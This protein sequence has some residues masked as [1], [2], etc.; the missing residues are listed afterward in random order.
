MYYLK[1]TTYA[2]LALLLL[3]TA[4]SKDEDPTPVGQ[5]PTANAG[6]DVQAT[7]NSSVPLN[8]SG[9]A[10]PD[11]GSLTYA[12]A[13]TTRPDGSSASIAGAAQATT[14]FTPDVVGTYVATLT[15]TDTDNNNASDAVTIEVS[16]AVGS[17]P[18]AAITDKNGRAIRE[19]N[20]N[21][22]LTVTS[23]Y[24]LDGSRSSDPDQDDLTYAWELA[25]KPEGSQTATISGSD[26][27]QAVFTPDV[28]GEYVI[29]LTVSDPGGNTNATDV[30]LVANASPVIVSGIISADTVWKDIFADPNVPDYLV[31]G[32][33]TAAAELTV[34]PGVVVHL[35]EDVVFTIDENGG[36]LIAEGTADQGIVFTSSDV[37]GEVRW[38]G[39]LINSSSSNNVLNY[40]TVS[41]AGGID[42]I[43]YEAG[44]RSA[45]I[46]ISADGRL[47]ITNTTVSH[48]EG[49]GM[50]TL[51]SASL[52]QFEN[53][54]FADNGNYA[55][56]ISINQAGVID[57]ATTFAD[58]GDTDKRENLVRI[59]DSSLSED[60][61]WTALNSNASYVMVGNVTLN[62]E[63]TVSPGT[64]LEFQEDIRMEVASGGALIANGTADSK[65]IF[66]T[67]SPENEQYWGGLLVESSSTKNLLNYIEISYAG[68]EDQ[69]IYYNGYQRASVAVADEANIAI[70]NTVFSN[71]DGYGLFASP[72]GGITAFAGNTFS[73]IASYPLYL[74]MNLVGMVDATTSIT[75]NSDNVVAVYASTL[76]VDA[77]FSD[78]ASPQ[79][80]TL[81][82]NAKY[83]ATGDLTISD[84]LVLAEGAYVAFVELA[85]MEVTASGS[86][87][88]IGSATNN[89]I[90]TAY[91]QSGTN[92]WGG[93][94]IASDDANELR[95][96]EVSYAGKE[97]QL[98]YISGYRA[99]NIAVSADGSLDLY[100]TTVSGSDAYGLVV[101]PGGEVNG[102]TNADT[103]PATTVKDANSFSGNE[104]PDEV[105]FF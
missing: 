71:G 24:T 6:G 47:K 69:L 77:S 1:N 53:N 36:V 57:A 33:L 78:P 84:D 63:L 87:K 54:M 22:T 102:L 14:T 43:I 86:I 13:L 81:A 45:G 75:N 103:D 34:A 4:C 37:A 49:D 82:E 18:V 10:D 62:A 28:V 88:A 93:L 26:Q 30:T 8:G 66:T 100:D 74:P 35:D 3:G 15:V 25:G 67:T 94:L 96:A 59:Y 20:K 90:L 83:L 79:W 2:L 60:Q 92:N 61:T 42:D 21:N 12:W 44:Y 89:V 58:N 52:A 32:N 48:H 73:G 68:G 85:T 7:V 11:G 5:P 72:A 9:S 70:T 98:I 27:D 17:P 65:I 56:S 50:F 23:P 91:D 97:D 38:G 101:G 19:D 95:N 29:R 41:Y 64:R 80:V 51:G 105:M 40:T 46:A 104:N 76:T 55:L 39:L 31:V 99:A 16:E